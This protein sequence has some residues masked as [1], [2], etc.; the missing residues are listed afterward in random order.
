MELGFGLL[1]S[2]A[3]LSFQEHAAVQE[4]LA[5]IPSTALDFHNSE[6]TIWQRL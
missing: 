3:R 4:S 5:R 1:A 6:L 2:G